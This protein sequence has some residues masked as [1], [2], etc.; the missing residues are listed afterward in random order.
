M[1]CFNREKKC[2]NGLCWYT[3]VYVMHAL[4]CFVFRQ[5]FF[6]GVYMMHC[7]V[8]LCQYFTVYCA[9]IAGYL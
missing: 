5:H 3:R 6:G 7:V 8:L 4:F 1:M 2:G 9:P